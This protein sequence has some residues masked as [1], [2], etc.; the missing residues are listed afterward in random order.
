M[1]FATYSLPP[2]FGIARRSKRR[3]YASTRDMGHVRAREVREREVR[4]WTLPYSKVPRGFAEIT[5]DDFWSVSKGVLDF[6]WT[7]P[8]ES[9]IRVRF[10]APPSVTWLNNHIVGMSLELEEVL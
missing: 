1:T 6:D 2:G 4:S 7:P 8:G 9:A 3:A 10:A 5:W